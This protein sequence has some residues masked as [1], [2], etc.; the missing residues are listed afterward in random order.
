M[1][2]KTLEYDQSVCMKS[3]VFKSQWMS[4][5]EKKKSDCKLHQMRFSCVPNTEAFITKPGFKYCP[6]Y[7]M[8][9]NRGIGRLCLCSGL[10]NLYVHQSL[11]L[12]IC[13][14][15]CVYVCVYMCVC[16]CVYMCMCICVYVCMYVCIY[17]CMCKGQK[18]TLNILS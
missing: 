12:S 5:L 18:T 17:V 13:V 7:I 4:K 3:L 1:V 8:E 11:D 15:M 2:G 10:F 14:F 16:I 9:E 6:S